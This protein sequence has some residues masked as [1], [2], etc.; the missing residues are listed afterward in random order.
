[1]LALSGLAFACVAFAAPDEAARGRAIYDAHCAACHGATLAGGF[2]PAL[3]GEAF[4]DKWRAKGIAA[5]RTY[6]AAAMPPGHAGKLSAEA[7]ADL[8]ALLA[9]ANSLPVDAAP[10]RNAMGR[11]VRAAER[12]EDTT[13]K[14]AFARRAALFAAMRPVDD[15]MLADPPAADWLHWRR[16]YDAQALSPLKA[17]DRRNVAGLAMAW[18]LGLASGANQI[19][20]LVHDGV[21]FL[22]SGKEV[23]AADA[24]SGDLLWRYTRPATPSAGTRSQPRSVALY[25]MRLFVPTIDGHMLALDAKTGALLWDHAIAGAE[26]GQ[27]VA[28]PIVARGKLIQGVAGCATDRMPGGCFLVALDPATGKELWRTHSIARPGEPGGESWNGAPLDKR[29][30]G[31]I[32]STASYDLATGLIY[33]GTGQTYRTATLRDPHSPAGSGNAALHTDSTLAIDPATGRIRWSYQ[34]LDRDIWDFDW[35]F[36]QTL[37]TLDGRRVVFSAGKLGIIDVLDARTGA[38]LF[39]RDLGLQRIVERIDSATGHKTIR[40]GLEPSADGPGVTMCPSSFGVRN[41]PATAYDPGTGRLYLPLQEACMDLFWNPGSA[42]DIS[43][44]LKPMPGSDG[45]FGR[46]EAVDLTSGRPVW[47]QRERAP[48]S[49]ALLATAGGLIFAGGRDRRF[50]ALDSA[51]GAPLWETR[52]SAAP[53]GFPITYAV[54]GRQ[55]VAI[56]AGG[57]GPLDAGLESFTPELLPPAGSPTLFVFALPDRR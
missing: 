8:A 1:M 25:G 10:Q 28:G 41:W 40:P 56:V 32:W 22:A 35:G 27:I 33:I 26:G 23:I 16:T 51:T 49:S 12:N 48:Q 37:A 39:A 46:I 29:F 21:L 42:W 4:A 2:G 31:G 9:S 50:R 36:E 20:P 24:A 13:A 7:Y 45:N 43:W 14:A 5:L 34:H 47:I 44:K 18:S 38:F 30:G 11:V 3:K 57:G 19:A 15:A 6:I 55:Y 52:L 53:N 17:I 54:K